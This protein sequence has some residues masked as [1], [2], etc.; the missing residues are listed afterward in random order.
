MYDLKTIG[1]W[2]AGLTTPYPARDWAL[3]AACGFL[4]GCAGIVLA[5]Y[6]FFATQTGSIVAASADVPRPPIPVS[7]DALKV[8]L[9]TYTARAADFAS[10]NFVSV[11]LSD[12]R[13]TKR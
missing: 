6:M 5:G 4:V 3:I 8:V 9:E 10:R 2:I 12:P 7:P 1:H 11:N 13:P